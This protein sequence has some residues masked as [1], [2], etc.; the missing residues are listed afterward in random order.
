MKVKNF[1]QEN[2]E[3][4]KLNSTE[5]INDDAT[6][7]DIISSYN[8]YKPITIYENTSGLVIDTDGG[9]TAL[10]V[11]GLPNLTPYCDNKHEI[12]MYFSYG[13]DAQRK[14]TFLLTSILGGAWLVMTRDKSGGNDYFVTTIRVTNMKSTTWSF[15]TKT[16]KSIDGS[17]I[18]SN[19]TDTPIKLYKMVVR[20]IED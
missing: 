15:A 4:V 17:N 16:K 2:G 13:N 6:L 20:K 18:I 3:T 10:T 1:K 5:I 14:N 12:D 7:N 19:V 11:N 8:S 9:A